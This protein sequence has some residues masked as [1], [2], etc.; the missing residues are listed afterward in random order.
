MENRRAKLGNLAGGT[1]RDGTMPATHVVFQAL[2]RFSR[3]NA[4]DLKSL[5]GLRLVYMAERRWPLCRDINRDK[6]DELRRDMRRSRTPNG[7]DQGVARL[8]TTWRLPPEAERRRFL[9]PTVAERFLATRF[10]CSQVIGRR[11]LAAGGGD[12]SPPLRRHKWRQKSTRREPWPPGSR[13]LWPAAKLCAQ[14]E[15]PP[16]AYAIDGCVG[17]GCQRG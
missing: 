3:Q 9:S 16:R 5:P 12:S 13:E 8:A 14:R 10:G 4:N 17:F 1:A 15:R 6:I 7:V 2:N 11:G